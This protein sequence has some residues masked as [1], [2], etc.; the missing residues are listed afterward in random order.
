[1]SE[2]HIL[3]FASIIPETVEPLMRALQRALAGGYRRVHLILSTPGGSVYHGLSLYN[4]LRGAPFETYTYN[5]GQVDSVGVALYCAGLR[6]LS[7]PQARFLMHGVRTR[8]SGQFDTRQLL[9][10]HNGLRLDGENICRIIAVTTGKTVEQVEQDIAA[11]LT[12]TPE[13]AREYGLAHDIRAELV[14]SGVELVTILDPLPRGDVA[15]DS[16]TFNVYTSIFSEA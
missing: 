9:E 10:L 4:F 13:Q 11:H 3:F 16:R 5:F 7:A 1:M 8:I 6:R 15:G 12:L 14:P 2:L